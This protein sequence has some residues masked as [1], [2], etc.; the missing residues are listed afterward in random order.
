MKYKH[1]VISLLGKEAEWCHR[2]GSWYIRTERRLDE[3]HS[4]LLGHLVFSQGQESGQVPPL[5]SWGSRQNS[6]SQGK[7]GETDQSLAIT[8]TV[9]C[10]LILSYTPVKNTHDMAAT[11]HL[12]TE[13]FRVMEWYARY[14]AWSFKRMHT[15]T[16]PYI[17]PSISC[18]SYCSIQPIGQV[19]FSRSIEQ[20]NPFHFRRWD[21]SDV[22]N[23]TPAWAWCSDPND[24]QV[25]NDVTDFP[26]AQMLVTVDRIHQHTTQ[27]PLDTHFW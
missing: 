11:C 9:R 17:F 8:S 10:I 21:I 1:D 15:C 16:F 19:H 4:L 20:R 13:C 22:R 12:V 25:G 27:G 23:V 2:T 26:L 14:R 18:F 7:Y 5:Y 6:N 3:C 24:Y